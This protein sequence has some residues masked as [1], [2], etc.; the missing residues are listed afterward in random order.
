MNAD[1]AK[2][3]AEH[4]AGILEHEIPTTAKVLSAVSHGN[5]NYKPDGKSRSALE[6]ASHIAVADNWFL[7]SV[8]EGKF[9]FDQDAATRAESQFKNGDEIAA[10]Y[11]HT[12]PEKLKQ[13]RA[14]PAEKLAQDVDF[15]GMMKAPAVT[16]LSLTTNHSVHHR[17]QLAAY[18][19]AMGSHVPSIY[20]GSADEPFQAAASV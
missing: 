16:F 20:G 11:Q 14:L 13:L 7:Q 12:V 4:Y 1:Q 9:E 15:F 3:L 19:R 5:P 2:F 17:G 8:I 18:L 10:F 6:L